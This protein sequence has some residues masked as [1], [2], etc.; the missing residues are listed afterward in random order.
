[1]AMTGAAVSP[2]LG[3]TLAALGKETVTARIDRCLEKLST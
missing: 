1:V 2:P 3:I